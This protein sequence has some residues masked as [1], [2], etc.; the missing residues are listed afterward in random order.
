MMPPQL[1]QMGYQNTGS[2]YAMMPPRNTMMTGMGMFDGRIHGSQSGAMPPAQGL[3]QR[4]MSTFSMATFVNPFAGPSM[5]PNPTDEDLFN[6]L[7]D[8]LSTQVQMTVT[9]KFVCHCILVICRLLCAFPFLKN[10]THHPCFQSL[11]FF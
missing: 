11:A 8:Y 4:P 3:H 1:P 9:K 10:C 6:A 7:R 5:N 2:M